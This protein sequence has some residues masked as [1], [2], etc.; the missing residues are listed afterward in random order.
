MPDIPSDLHYN[1]GSSMKYGN[2]RGIDYV[3]NEL[4]KKENSSRAIIP[5][6]DFSSVIENRNSFLPSFNIIQFGF[7]KEIFNISLYMRS[8]E[9]N[10]FLYINIYELYIII[11][12]ILLRLGKGEEIFISLNIYAFQAQFKE[13]FGCFRKAKLD[14]ITEGELTMLICKREYNCLKEMIEEKISLNETIVQNVGF[15][16][17]KSAFMA[18]ATYERDN[19]ILEKIIFKLDEIIYKLDEIKEL[20]QV[21]N[22]TK[23]KESELKVEIKKILAIFGEV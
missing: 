4:E 17:L 7:D 11:N 19:K 15:S 16:H 8:V 1:H 22:D 3:I 20:R 23:L 2:I 13:K 14:S 5:L 10:N 21:T 12:E 18:Y 6:I 9:V